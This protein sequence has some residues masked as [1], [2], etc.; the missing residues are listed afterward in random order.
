MKNFDVSSEH[1]QVF[2]NCNLRY[3]HTDRF[4]TSVLKLSV[5]I[6]SDNDPKSVAMFSLMINLLRSGTE[7]YP[8]KADIIK[9][10]NDLYDATCSIGGYA[11]G[12]NRIFE[13]SSEMLSDRFSDGESIFDGICE[14]MHQML[15]RPF[16]DVDGR[17]FKER[18]EREKKTILDRIKSEK[19]NSREYAFKKCR[20]A[21][22]E[23]EPYGQSVKAS[24][25]KTITQKQISDYY[26]SFVRGLRLEFSYVGDKSSQEVA[27]TLKKYFEG[28]S[29]TSGSCLIPLTAKTPDKLTHIEEELDVKQGVL[30][31]GMRT[32]ILLHNELSCAMCVF[33]N[34]YGGTFSSR[35]FKLIREKMSMCYYISSDY[36]TTK[37]LMFVSCGIDIN[38]RETVE[39]TILG[40]LDRLKNENVTEEELDVAKKLAVKELYDMTDYPNAIATFYFSRS[41]YGV[42]ITIK[43]FIDKVSAVSLD[44]IKRIAQKIIPDT[45]F[46]LKGTVSD[47]EEGLYE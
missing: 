13:M 39:K 46:F 4:K 34:I 14:L 2:D 22:C 38:N 10:R 21:M 23:G 5:A 30:I 37:G 8:E 36:V 9:R 16:L 24:S 33:N 42:D 27:G 1:I 31:V 29:V 44:D 32:G 28:A 7:K 35:L 11:S 43:D 41:I 12:D 6:P 47:E 15:L 40:E 45:V 20:E 26:K 17:F 3:Y 18:V 19:N 25:I